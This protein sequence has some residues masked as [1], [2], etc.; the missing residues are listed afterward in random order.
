VKLAER[1]SRSASAASPATTPITPTRGG[2]DILLGLTVRDLDA[3]AFNRYALPSSTRGVLITR[4]EPLS[5][6]SEAGLQRGN[7][8]L[9]MNRKAVTSVADYRRAASA[10]RVGDILTLF[11]YAPEAG[12]RQLKTLRVDDR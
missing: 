2:D 5:A 6:A 7:V 11:L 9:E 8:L 10:A 4:V 12:Q 3:Q 1:P